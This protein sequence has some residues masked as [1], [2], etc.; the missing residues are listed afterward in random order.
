[1]NEQLQEKC[2]LFI[3]NKEALK[4]QFKWDSS[5]VIPACSML[6]TEHN[7]TVNNEKIAQCNNI[8]KKRTGAFSNLRG[9]VKPVL[10]SKM[11]FSDFA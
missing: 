8:L 6:Y 2:Q 4:K 3:Q 7:N 1:M 10:I 11:A 5:Y 9:I